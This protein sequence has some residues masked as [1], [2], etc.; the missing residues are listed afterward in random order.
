VT[1]E[2]RIEARDISFRIGGLRILDEV[3]VSVSP[4]GVTGLVGPNGAGKTTLMDIVSGLTKPSRGSVSLRGRDVTNVS[5]SKR[6]M[7]GLG[8]TY[9]DGRVPVGLTVEETVMVGALYGAGPTKS[10]GEARTRARSALERVG[11]ISRSE[12]PATSVSSGQQKLMDIARVLVMQPAAMLLDEPLAALSASNQELV[13]D[14][15][16]EQCAAGCSIFLVEHVMRAVLRAS[17]R[18]VVLHEGKVLC[19][20][21]P[22]RVVR[23]ERVIDAYLGA[24]LSESLDLEHHE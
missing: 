17:D 4:G 10:V 14:I 19:D 22:E 18:V 13:L 7:L 12:V 8:R 21:T 2:E 1:T 3:S 15:V 11:L 5:P 16:K 23:D 6:A 24:E 9:Q 20:D